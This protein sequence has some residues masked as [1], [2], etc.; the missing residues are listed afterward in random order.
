MTEAAAS[1][2]RSAGA[3]ARAGADGESRFG[4]YLCAGGT[5]AVWARSP[6][7]NPK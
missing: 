3:A 6:S 2:T 7:S 5:Q 1:L 4:G